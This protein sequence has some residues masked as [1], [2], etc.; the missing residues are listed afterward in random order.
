MSAYHK[1]THLLFVAN[2][3]ASFARYE[4]GA[5]TA[6]FN[7]RILFV[8]PK[9][10]DVRSSCVTWIFKSG[11]TVKDCSSELLLRDLLYLRTHTHTVCVIT[12]GIQARSRGGRWSWTHKLAQTE[13]IMS[14]EV[15]LGCESWTSFALG[16]TCSSTAVQRTLSL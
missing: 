3:L 14:R 8:T 1:L 16:Q 5:I 2:H 6:G 9:F 4:S 10:N 12:T 13:E 15:E 7:G 11:N